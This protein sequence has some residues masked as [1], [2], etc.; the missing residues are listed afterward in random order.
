MTVTFETL[1]RDPTVLYGACGGLW[2]MILHAPPTK[3]GML[4]ARPAL[5]SMVRR[6]PSGF[7]TLTW[8]LGSAGFR[9]DGDARTAAAD[10]TRAFEPQILAQATLVEG[11][12]FQTAAVRAILTGLDAMS[13]SAKPK[14]VF[15]S[16]TEAVAWSTSRPGVTVRGPTNEIVEALSAVHTGLGD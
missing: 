16:L 7:S 13:G 9:M 10:V 3:A 4:L 2:V 6:I 15:S 11:E 12:G 14:R 8:I 5:E 1:Q